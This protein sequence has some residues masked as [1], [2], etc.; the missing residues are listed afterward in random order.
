MKITVKINVNNLDDFIA[1]NYQS[2]V[3][4][5]RRCSSVDPRIAKMDETALSRGDDGVLYKLLDRSD[6]DKYRVLGD[7]EQRDEW[8]RSTEIKDSINTLS[9]HLKNGKYTKPSARDEGKRTKFVAPM[10]GVS[11]RSKKIETRQWEAGVRQLRSSS[12]NEIP[13]REAVVTNHTLK[14]LAQNSNSSSSIVDTIDTASQQTLIPTRPQQKIEDSVTRA[15]T[16]LRH[17]Y[18]QNLVAVEKLFDEK[19]VMERKI[20]L[21]EERLRLTAAGGG[22]GGDTDGIGSSSTDSLYGEPIDHDEFLPPSYQ[23]LTSTRSA[24]VPPPRAGGGAGGAGRYSAQDIALKFSDEPS[25]VTRAGSSRSSSSSRLVP[26]HARPSSAGRMSLSNRLDEGDAVTSSRFE[27][28][29]SIRRSRSAGP[30]RSAGL[31]GLSSHLQADADRYVQKRRLLDEQERV[32]KL[33]QQQWEQLRKEK[34]LRVRPWETT[35]IVCF[36]L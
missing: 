3:T 32:R 15:A 11:S 5:P 4:Q 36:I 35:L 19:V 17:K 1:M 6:W 24:S 12:P 16:V 7:R 29:G 33:E 2:F 25:V 34:I 8:T 22:G 20:Q 27:R 28:P 9:G 31:E 13:S 14:R 30:S 26:H 10:L 23:E 18:E 21:L